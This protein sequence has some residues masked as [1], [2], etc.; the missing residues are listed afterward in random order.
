MYNHMSVW[1][2]GLQKGKKSEKSEKL[3]SALDVAIS[4]MGHLGE[5]STVAG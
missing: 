1:I 3:S 2:R 5:A 4:Q